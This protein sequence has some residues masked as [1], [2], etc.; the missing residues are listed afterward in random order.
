MF[1]L[2]IREF[3]AAKCRA[4]TRIP[5]T[6]TLYPLQYA[7]T[8]VSIPRTPQP[9]LL[10]DG[11]VSNYAIPSIVPRH[12]NKKERGKMPTAVVF[13]TSPRPPLASKHGPRGAN[14]QR[15]RNK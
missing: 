2:R 12:L 6:D 14:P 4:W 15:M 3:Q 11:A 7:K 5:S 13:M 9:G 8:P 10:F 1:S